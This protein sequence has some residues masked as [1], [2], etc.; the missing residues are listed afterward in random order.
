MKNKNRS[1][2]AAI[3]VMSVFGVQAIDAGAANGLNFIGFGNESQYMAGADTAVA[4]D[5]SALSTNPAGMS[6]ITGSLIDFHQIV[7]Y[8]LDTTHQ[9]AFN[10]QTEVS[11]KWYFGG[12]IGFVKRRPDNKLTWG[13]GLFGQGGTGNTYDQLNTAFG[14]RDRLSAATAIAK[15]AGGLAYE[16]D[17]DTSVGVSVLGY[18]AASEQEV[19]P[20]TSHVNFQGF[21][22]KGA[23]GA[24]AGVR[25]GIR[26]RLNDA[27]TAGLVYGSPVKLDLEDGRMRV[28][29]TALGLG[30]VNYR[31]A[32]ITGLRLP[33]EV[34][35]GLAWQVTP[36][37]LLSTKFMW[38]DWSNALRSQTLTARDPDN[39]FA[40]AQITS[41]SALNWRDQY[42][43]AIGTQYK[44]TPRFALLAGYNYGRSPQ[45]AETTSPIF[46]A[47][48]QHH[49]TLGYHYQWDQK[50]RLSAGIEY[51]FPETVTYTNAQLPFGSN[52]V[53]RGEL[54]YFHLGISHSW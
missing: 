23:A 38:L 15:L 26:H 40:P 12:D 45:P 28:N 25:L 4:R 16:V 52:V 37:W 7:L 24:G 29:M 33:Q 34:A 42:V 10:Q 31:D 46:I 1:A 48:S 9:D 41:T 14:T 5:S 50:T 54:L 36:D 30:I 44:V 19:F 43:F 8:V 11:K 2:I 20:N 17:P 13:I 47:G 39:T 35:A 53:S 51:V 6:Q 18:Y 21:E 27:L 49:L 32:S 3:A 22:L